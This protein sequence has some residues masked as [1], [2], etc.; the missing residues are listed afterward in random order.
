MV[1]FQAQKLPRTEDVKNFYE[2]DSKIQVANWWAAALKVSNG[3][4]RYTVNDVI[5]CEIT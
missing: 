5:K 2:K 3:E 4:V 1:H